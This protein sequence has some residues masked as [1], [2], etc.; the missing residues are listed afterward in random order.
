MELAYGQVPLKTPTCFTT[1]VSELEASNLSSVT[2]GSSKE[3]RMCDSK[4]KLR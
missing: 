4:K 3:S 1:A 2:W